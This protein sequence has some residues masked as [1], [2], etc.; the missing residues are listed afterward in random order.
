MVGA[1]DPNVPPAP[2]MSDVYRFRS[3]VTGRYFYT[4]D[5]SEKDQL[6]KE[7]P[8]FWT[9]EG[10]AFKAAAKPDLPDLA[11]VYRFWSPTQ[12]SHFYTI[13]EEEKDMIIRQWPD[14][15]SFE[16]V[17]FYA[18]PEGKQPKETKPVYRFWNMH[19]GSHFYTMDESEKD[20]L[21]KEFADVYV[22]ESI[23][24]YTYE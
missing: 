9:Y 8:E 2:A 20:K 12:L 23:A 21:I 1:D 11:P 14:V 24:F 17:A 16:T 3:P 5:A 6:I 18:Y 19:D 10:P 7:Y 13:N 15:W 22:F 4:I